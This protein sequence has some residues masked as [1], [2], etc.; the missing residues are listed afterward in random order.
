MDEEYWRRF[1]ETGKIID[2]LNYKGMAICKRVMDNYTLGASCKVG[3]DAKGGNPGPLKG[4]RGEC[5]ESD[6]GDRYGA[7]GDTCW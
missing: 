4:E 7:C 6:Y 1:L 5:S 2:Y 3:S